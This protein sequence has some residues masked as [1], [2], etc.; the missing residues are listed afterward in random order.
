MGSCTWHCWYMGMNLGPSF[1]A[2]NLKIEAIQI[3]PPQLGSQWTCSCTNNVTYGEQTFSERDFPIGHFP[4][5][6]FRPTF[7]VLVLCLSDIRL[8]CSNLG[9]SYLIKSD[10]TF[11][12]RDFCLPETKSDL[13]WAY[14]DIFP[15]CTFNCLIL[16]FA[17]CDICLL[18]LL[19]TVTFAYQ[20]YAYQTFADFFLGISMKLRAFM[21]FS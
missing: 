21:W 2:V 14:L 19:P 18:W 1:L 11:A 12:Y 16:T 20:T 17:Y 5:D 9:I 6:I 3:F 4:T 7:H 10:Q 15:T 8:P 13:T